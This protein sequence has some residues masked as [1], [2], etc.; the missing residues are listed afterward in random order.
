[1][2]NNIYRNPNYNFPPT[3]P[4][5]PGGM[6]AY[7]LGMAPMPPPRPQDIAVAM[8]N[9]MLDNPDAGARENNNEDENIDPR[10]RGQANTQAASKYFYF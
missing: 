7:L 8:A 1:M 10:L 4:R 2:A 3:Q 9:R 6:A 5:N